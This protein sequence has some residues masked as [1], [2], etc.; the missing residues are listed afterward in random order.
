MKRL[1][2]ILIPL[3]LLLPG[4]AAKPAPAP[5]RS[6]LPRQQSHSTP[7]V[8][9]YTEEFQV[10]VEPRWA[11]EVSPLVADPEAGV[12]GGQDGEL[13]HFE[14]RPGA[15]RY[16]RTTYGR[17]DPASVWTG[18]LVW[19]SPDLLAG[20][21]ITLTLAMRDASGQVTDLGPAR[22]PGGAPFDLLDLWEG[23][24]RLRA[25]EGTWYTL[26][27]GGVELLVEVLPPSQPVDSGVDAKVQEPF[28]QA[29]GGRF[30]AWG[31]TLPNGAVY[32]LIRREQLFTYEVPAKRF[33][34]IGQRSPEHQ[35]PFPVGSLDGRL[36][37]QLPD[38][39]ISIDPA[40]G[41]QQAVR[42]GQF[43]DRPYFSPDGWAYLLPEAA[44]NLRTGEERRLEPLPLTGGITKV[45]PLGEGLLAAGTGHGGA[46]FLTDTATGRHT[47]LGRPLP[48]LGQQSGEEVAPIDGLARGADGFLYAQV[49]S[50]AQGLPQSHLVR[51]D[52]RTGKT[53]ASV[54]LEEPAHSLM[55][56]A[57]GRL[58]A[59]G[60]A[61]VL[62][63][64]LP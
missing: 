14:V 37:A 15:R 18:D 59:A 28:E 30:R 21:T 22:S 55:A 1:A 57:D 49:G 3:V 42:Q 19:L 31:V 54:R 45:I 10:R 23:A 25:E 5:E 27:S 44:F 40:S 64:D 63:I 61:R 2:M 29:A 53:V 26:G 9:A 58:Y 47:M 39:L 4:C 20:R 35:G 32:A 33:A 7:E 6:V 17:P 12:W 41:R 50:G 52:P 13:F 8:L 16:R 34:L 24:L 60:R 51:I 38:A 11:P 56:G 43:Y 62:V 48:D 46:L 36:L